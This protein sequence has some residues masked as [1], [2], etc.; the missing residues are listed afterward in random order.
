ML[1]QWRPPA[2]ESLAGPSPRRPQ[3]TV[4]E[5]EH[6][7]LRSRAPERILMHCFH[8]I[9]SAKNLRLERFNNLLRMH[10]W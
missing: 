9:D 1:L 3:I 4:E 2:L 7:P 8:L 10:E 5:C 6:L